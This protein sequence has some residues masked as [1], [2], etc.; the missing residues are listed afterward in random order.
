MKQ[1]SYILNNI[2]NSDSKLEKTNP[3]NNQLKNS[4]KMTDNAKNS[5][6]EEA[7][8]I[9]GIIAPDGMRWDLYGNPEFI[10]D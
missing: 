8:I 6:L 5:P 2:F 4:K 10:E 3:L 7:I 1:E 9:I